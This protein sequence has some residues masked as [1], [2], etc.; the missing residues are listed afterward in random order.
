LFD[1][2]KQPTTFHRS[3]RELDEERKKVD[4]TLSI[5]ERC[6]SALT[7]LFMHSTLQITGL[8]SQQKRRASAADCR[9]RVD[10]AGAVTAA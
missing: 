7:Q 9:L 6:S 10:D 2:N 8:D 4:G 1:G 3:Y 5:A